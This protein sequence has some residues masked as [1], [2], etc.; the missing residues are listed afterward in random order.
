MTGVFSIAEV[1]ES[2]IMRKDKTIFC[3]ILK[4]GDLEFNKGQIKSLNAVDNM[5]KKYNGIWCQSLKE[6][7]NYLNNI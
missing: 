5:V 3:I 4:D 7:A 2:A 1:I 6:V